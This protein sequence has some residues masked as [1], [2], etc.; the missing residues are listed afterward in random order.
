MFAVYLCMVVLAVT[1]VIGI[2]SS[3]QRWSY[4]RYRPTFGYPVQIVFEAFMYMSVI[5]VP[6]VL[7]VIIIDGSL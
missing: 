7:V 1:F 2:F 6:I 4:R 3:V 5:G